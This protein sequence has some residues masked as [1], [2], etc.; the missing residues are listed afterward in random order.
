VNRNL[1]AGTLLVG[2]FVLAI[3]VAGCGAGGRPET[4]A[5]GPAQPGTE[6]VATVAG[7]SRSPAEVAAAAMDKS[8]TPGPGAELSPLR[9][10]AFRRPVAEYRS[11]A[12]RQASSMQG[13]V[14]RLRRAL[15]EGRRGAAK[16]SWYSAYDRYLRLGAAYGALG[17]LD[18][19]IDGNPGQLP[20]GTS[21]PHFT[22]LHRIELG[23]W[24]GADTQTL[25]G[26][27]ALLAAD[28]R[29]LRR[30]VPTMA[31]SPLEYATRAHEILEDAQRDML[32]GVDA[33]W[34]GAG[35]RATADSLAATE[36]VIGTLRPLLAG[37][38]NAL[39][40]VE[41]GIAELHGQL[42]RV[43]RA[44]GGRWPRLEAMT[45][46]ERERVDG[47]LGALLEQLA[48]VPGTLE[49]RP[50]RQIPTI[51]SEQ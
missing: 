28:V 51:A 17:D 48:A 25:A 8:H 13:D 39:Q 16:R 38:G 47:S 43:R 18:R 3:T 27:A 5:T 23:L 26:Q 37:R 11:Y 15:R 44:H 45:K 19:A 9:P 49:T 1:A 32:S 4:E 7:T 41:S 24:T 2:A 20:G 29:H 6:Q 33:P 10:A 46:I 14:A 50:P 36:V 34:S 40:P 30:I 42:Q 21:D 35:L 12:A 22:G 31:I